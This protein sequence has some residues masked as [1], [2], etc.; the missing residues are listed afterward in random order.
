MRHQRQ[1][2]LCRDF[3]KYNLKYIAQTI[4]TKT[5]KKIKRVV[6]IIRK[7]SFLR[8]VQVILKREV[9]VIDTKAIKLIL[10]Y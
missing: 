7:E 1:N 3:L 8:T 9:L 10:K 4:Y 5:I 6:L 2:C